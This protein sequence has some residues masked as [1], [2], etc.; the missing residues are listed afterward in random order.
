M[1]RWG[2]DADEIRLD[3]AVAVGDGR[4]PLA[5]L[6]ARHRREWPGTDTRDDSEMIGGPGA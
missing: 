2:R 1:S 4:E 6:E 5:E 3:I